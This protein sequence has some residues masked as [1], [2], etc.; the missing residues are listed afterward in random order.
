MALDRELV[1]ALHLGEYLGLRLVL[2]GIARYLVVVLGQ[3]VITRP[4]Q[5]P[6][7]QDDREVGQV[8]PMISTASVGTHLAFG[9][10]RG[11]EMPDQITHVAA[12]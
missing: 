3:V 10:A 5:Q 1:P 11:D 8:D 12:E 4:P 9:P 2:A 7:R 6:V